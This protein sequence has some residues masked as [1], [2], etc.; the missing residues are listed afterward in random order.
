MQ[1][2]KGLTN[3]KEISADNI[4]ATLSGN[5][6]KTGKFVCYYTF[7]DGRYE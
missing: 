1:K 3:V 7:S 2:I 4:K 5:S 6:R